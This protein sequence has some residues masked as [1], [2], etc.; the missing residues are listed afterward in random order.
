M[1]SELSLVVDHGFGSY[2]AIYMESPVIC[3]VMNPTVK[4]S[5]SDKPLLSRATNDGLVASLCV[6]PSIRSWYVVRIVSFDV[7]I[8]MITLRT[9]HKKIGSGPIK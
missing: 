4:E 9:E 5:L 7:R 1:V 6:C 2:I 8:W 3:Q